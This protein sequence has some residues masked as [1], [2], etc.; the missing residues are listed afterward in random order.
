[1]LLVGWWEGKRCGLSWMWK[2]LRYVTTTENNR[3]KAEVTKTTDLFEARLSY[4]T[5]CL[6]A[7]V[8]YF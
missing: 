6:V 4:L 3:I 2:G 7:Y 1:M 8:G 5:E